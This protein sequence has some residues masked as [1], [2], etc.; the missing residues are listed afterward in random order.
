MST[1]SLITPKPASPVIKVNGVVIPQEAI[2]AEAQHHPADRPETAWQSATEALVIR[3]ALLQAAREREVVVDSKNVEE[4]EGVEEDLLI[5]SFLDQEVKIPEPDDESCRRYFDNNRQKLRSPDI[6]EPSHILLQAHKD[7]TVVY[8]RAREEA[9]ALIDH[10]KDKPDTFARLASDR[11]DCESSTH[12]GRLGQI[13]KGQ[14]TPLFEKAMLTLNPGEL[15]PHPVETPYGFHV[16]RLDQAETGKTPPFELAKP[17]VEEFL[18]DASW[19]RAVAQFVSLVVG[20]A[21][22]EGVEL[23]GATSPL[24]Q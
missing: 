8:E 11:S 21:K 17:L 13:T 16:L 15:C 24:V 1:H 7:D 23:N 5:Q 18:R 22:I 14:T 12:G 4:G 10:L 9:Q 3:E 20:D 2:A 6:Y 19:R